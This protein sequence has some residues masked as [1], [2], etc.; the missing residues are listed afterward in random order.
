MSATAPRAPSRAVTP[1]GASS[2]RAQG[3]VDAS[4]LD[5]APARAISSAWYC[6]GTAAGKGAS[7]G[8][9]ITGQPGTVTAAT[10][11]GGSVLLDSLSAKPVTAQLRA[12]AVDGGQV[13]HSYR[14][15]PY[16]Q[17]VVPD[18]TFAGT[19]FVG[20]TV[21]M[22]GGRAVVTEEV[23]GP[24]GTAVA[25][26]ASGASSSWYLPAGSTEAGHAV[27][28][29]VLNPLPTLA[30]ID[31]GFATPGI[32]TSPSALQGA[33]VP[34][35][36]VVA[37]NVSS[38]LRHARGI[39]TTVRA[40]TGMVVAA[41][42]QSSTGPRPGISLTLG[43]SG[44]APAS[45]FPSGS[46]SASVS[47][48]LELFNP[49]PGP[50]RALVSLRLAAPH[51]AER[52]APVHETLG[53]GG[54]AWVSLNG[55]PRLPA[56]SPLTISVHALGGRRLVAAQSRNFAGP[57]AAR[58]VL[59]GSG[60]GRSFVLPALPAAQ[61]SHLV[62]AGLVLL[63]GSRVATVQVSKL[64]PSG[65]VTVQ[66]VTVPARGR[67]TL[68]YPAA[69]AGAALR[70]ESSSPVAVEAQGLVGSGAGGAV[71]M[72]GIPLPR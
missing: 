43:S 72:A 3:T 39:M 35:G 71:C 1:I 24:L 45:Y 42:L 7:T 21:V 68:A 55:Q 52:L 62:K 23:S 8:Q 29:V 30:V 57:P 6:A 33:A 40:T 11:G 69:E 53:A 13:V 47:G 17:L 58:C 56:S 60:L 25:P 41:E 34:A 5:V 9:V 67:A 26:C 48:A 2:A 64:G 31:V 51:P 28:V 16:G 44:G 20:V 32:S 61:A 22:Q 12:S 4:V 19:G 14:L 59:R 54:A 27:S 46:V 63:G 15:A 10:T 36:R 38:S 66:H 37:F 18:S 49:G 50:A 70:V 65:L